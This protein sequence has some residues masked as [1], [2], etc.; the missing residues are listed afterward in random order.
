MSGALATRL[1]EL[2]AE[3]I[4]DRNRRPWTHS[5][6]TQYRLEARDVI[7]AALGVLGERGVEGRMRR[8]QDG[9]WVSLA[10]IRDLA[11]V[12]ERGEQT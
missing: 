10:A 11:G 6:E 2:G 9:D 7:A 12:V 8:D 3:K 1:I 4:A 5:D